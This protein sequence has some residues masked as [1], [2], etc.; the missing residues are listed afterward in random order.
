[1]IEKKI[2][3]FNDSHYDL[4]LKLLLSSDLDVTIID[5]KDVMASK[6]ISQLDCSVHVNFQTS[7]FSN[8]NFSLGELIFGEFVEQ[9]PDIR[10]FIKNPQIH[11]Y[12][13]KGMRSGVI[14]K[15]LVRLYGIRDYKIPEMVSVVKSY[16]DFR[17]EAIHTKEV[18]LSDI[19][20]NFS[21]VKDKEENSQGGHFLSFSKKV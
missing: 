12:S 10:K 20:E 3:L 17:A 11:D 13:L 14:S 5:E 19:D 7:N 16:K 2:F 21:V 4:M 1:M 6:L 8:I 9:V 18:K 15:K